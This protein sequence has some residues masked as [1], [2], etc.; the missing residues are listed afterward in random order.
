M[1]VVNKTTKNCGCDKTIRKSRLVKRIGESIPNK[2]GL[3]VTIIKYINSKNIDVTFD[4]G[5][6]IRN[7]GYESFK[8]GK[9]LHPYYP[10]KEWRGYLGDGKYN[11]VDYKTIY[12]RWIG[13]M[14]RCY[15]QEIQ[16]LHPTY[17]GCT[18][19]DEWHNFQNYA[20]WYEENIWVC[21]EKLEVDKDILV[22]GNK[23]YSPEM[24]ILTT[25][26]INTLFTKSNN[27]RGDTPIGV[28]KSSNTTYMARLSKNNKGV[29]L[30][31]YKDTTE[32]FN[33]YK[34]GKE[35]YIKQ[36]ADEYKSRY[37]DFPKRLYDAMYNYEVEIT[38]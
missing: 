26:Y 20:K 12:R 13:M 19:C 6:I 31:T 9:L 30:G 11:F 32:A 2:Q 28:I 8:K 36:I 17:I 22:K 38:D 21:D 14:K 7:R 24:C 18:V 1:Q 37:P 27:M 3:N 29:N 5:Y 16:E 4:D 25:K 34:I 35:S 23:V 33:A 15:L 10:H